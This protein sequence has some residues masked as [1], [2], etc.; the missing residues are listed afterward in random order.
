MNDQDA[1]TPLCDGV[2]A[3]ALRTATLDI[4]HAVCATRFSD[5]TVKKAAEISVS[6]RHHHRGGM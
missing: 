5:P 3:D 6:L 1:W 2:L 4:A